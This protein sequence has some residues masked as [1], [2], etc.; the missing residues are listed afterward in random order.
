MKAVKASLASALERPDPK[1]RFY[2]FHGPDEAGSRALAMQLL[3]GLGDA[4]K[5]I[6]LGQ[7]IKA[8][9]AALADEA[10][11]MALFGGKRAIWVEPAGDEIAEGVGALLDAPASESAV[12]ALA[13]SIRKT[14]A[15]LKL[16]EAHP[17]ALAHCSY[18][19][20][21]R[22]ME[23]VVIELGRKNGLRIM[24]A[25]A[26]RIAGAT[27]NNQAIAAQELGKFALYLGADTANPCDLDQE[28]LDLL[29]ADSAEADVMRLGDLALAGRMNELIDELGRLPS[30]GS[31]AIPVLRSLQ[32]RLLMLAPLRARV[33][34][35][36]SVDSV[37][38]SM[39]KSLFWKDKPLI[40]RLLSVWS[41]ERLTEAAAR[42][43]ALERQIMLRPLS[44][45]AAL[46]E[47]LVTLARAAR[48]KG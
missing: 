41:A 11:A 29:G 3:K 43:S 39:G 36:Q 35:G 34:Q 13:G 2:L 45:E 14:S 21:G 38:T 26:Q 18:V 22:D 32:R 12:V 46:G 48:Q 44:D 7:S 16:A 28:T 33:E 31:E 47:M 10:G 8:D 20:E 40:Q 27:S 23:R 37:M 4:E 6:V 15:L 9:P 24:P 30:G 42:V 17:A 1:I 5:F 25:I 19:P